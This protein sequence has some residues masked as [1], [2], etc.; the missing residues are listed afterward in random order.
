MDAEGSRWETLARSHTFVRATRAILFVDVF[1]SVRL[2]EEDE[3]GTL[4]RWLKI[5]DHVKDELLPACG[6]HLVKSVGDGMLLEFGDVPAAVPTA[7]A[8][9][10]LANRESALYPPEQKMLLRV[11]IEVGEV[12][13]ERDDLFG[14]G[15]NMAVRLCQLAGPGEIVVS[16]QVKDHITADLDA[17]IEDLGECY[18]RHVKEPVRAYRI[19]PPG[20]HPVV[21]S[22]DFSDMLMPTL[23]VVPFTPHG[24]PAEHQL[25]GEVL[26]EEV[27]RALSQ[28]P[29]LIVISRLSTTAFSRRAATPKEISSHLRADYVVT[30]TYRS[31]GQNVLL[32]LEVAEAKSGQIA[33]TIH[34]EGGLADVLTGDQELIARVVSDIS[35]AVIARELQRARSR[36]LPTL[37]GYTLLIAAIT[38]MHRLSLRDFEE[39]RHMLQTLI[40]RRPRQA[41][42]QAWLAKWHVLRVQ[43]GW[44]VDRRHDAASALECSRRALDADP[45]C[46]LALAMD[47]LAHTHLSKR[48]D[49]AQE[50]YEAAVETNP[51]DSQAWL[52]KGTL[53]AFKGEG[54]KAVRDTQRALMLSPLDPHRW[55]Y[56]SLAATACLA[57]HKYEDAL[58][59]ARR[60]L[61]ANRTHTSTLRA[62][63]VAQ[64]YLDRQDEARRTTEELLRLEPHLTV[65]SWLER[66]PSAA[67]PIGR[68]WAGI[69]QHLGIPD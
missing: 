35:D 38:L 60:S 41:I 44:S 4:K 66:S 48:L 47:G 52:L 39:A 49:L 9:Q 67:Y 62:I 30:G 55:Y 45:N 65:S 28:S 17:D 40:D 18:L 24:V 6:G 12:I 3:A 10:N 31:D 1:E 20:P 37:K 51:N 11:G 7:F 22:G 56:D 5:V 50:R 61:H 26:A 27:I 2:I 33:R 68:E 8:L 69:F 15:V 53:H 32:N 14:R 23:A 57:A 43:Q 36:P 59:L 42:P 34:V 29:E 63:A 58:V 25:L 16:A 19:G 46:S 21:T 54:E 64:W 13:V